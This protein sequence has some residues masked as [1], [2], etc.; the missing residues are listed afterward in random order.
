MRSKGRKQMSESVVQFL[1]TI[2]ER[3]LDEYDMQPPFVVRAVGDNGNALVAHINEQGQL[4]LATERRENETF[5][6][7]L[8][9]NI[10]GS[11]KTARLFIERDGD[12]GRFH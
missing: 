4:F 9:I 12:I 7:P 11:G 6:L 5:T 8:N 3:C 1:A 2:I 10:V